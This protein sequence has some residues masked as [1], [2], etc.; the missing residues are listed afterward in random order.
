MKRR[1]NKVNVEHFPSSHLHNA[2]FLFFKTGLKNYFYL[3]IYL[4]LFFALFVND[5][6]SCPTWLLELGIIKTFKINECPPP[7]SAPDYSYYVINVRNSQKTLK[8]SLDYNFLYLCNSFYLDHIPELDPVSCGH[9][10]SCSLLRKATFI[11][12]ITSLIILLTLIY[13]KNLNLNYVKIT[14]TFCFFLLRKW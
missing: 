10:I 11:I 12:V 5:G 14:I 4:F 8:G 6:F 13:G 9:C 2:P 7:G 1:W 3:F